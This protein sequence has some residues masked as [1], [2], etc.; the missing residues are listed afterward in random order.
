[1][2]RSSSGL[3]VARCSALIM[4]LVGAASCSSNDN[5]APAAASPMGA[6]GG[7]V[8]GGTGGGSMTG[9]SGGSGPS[10][11]GSASDIATRL[12]RPARFLVGMGNDLNNDH[13]MDGAYTLGVTLDL[14]DAY[15][16]GANAFP[17]T[18]W[19]TNPDGAFVNVLCDSAKRHGVVPMFTLYSMA[20]S[21]E[22]NTAVLTNDG[23]MK[24]YWTEAQILFQRL[25]AYGDP[26]IVHLEPDWWAFA[27]QKS[28]GD[29]TTTAAHVGSVLPDCAGQPE[30]LVGMGKCLVALAR[31][32][33]PK[34]VV[35]FHASEWADPDPAKIGAF[36]NKIGSQEADIVVIDSLDRDAGCFETHTDPNCQRMDGPWYWDETNQTSPNF[37]EHLARAKAISEAT[38]KPILWWQTPFGVPSATRGGTSGHYR[39]NRVKY[40]FDHPD[41]YIAAGGVGAAFG[42]G[43][44]NQTDWMT[45]GGQFKTAVSKYLSAPAPL[46]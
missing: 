32:Y 1:M 43:A 36:L 21:G 5:T 9:G 2:P 31:K 26:A 24:P 11:T 10:G 6:G 13:D 46:P 19:N 44:G 33:A 20:S 16:V 7:S 42:T 35:G 12:G 25:G 29:P 4:L 15:L 45:D 22:S 8:T 27:Q 41:E 17:W 14:H 38:G 3:H 18:K 40:I 39:D 23:Y 37:H 30:T 34:V 28:G